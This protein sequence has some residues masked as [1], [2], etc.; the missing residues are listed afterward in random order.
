MTTVGKFLLKS[1]FALS[2]AGTCI[3]IGEW[4]RQVRYSV[5]I[6]RLASKMRPWH[7]LPGQDF[8]KRE[9]FVVFLSNLR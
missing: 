1:I 5:I 7:T 8:S 2:F 4:L 9:R 3:Y 6:V